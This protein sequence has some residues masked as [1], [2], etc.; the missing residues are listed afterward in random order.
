MQFMVIVKATKD[1]EAGIMPGKELF[2]AM[3]KYNEEL[4][5]AG[6]LLAAEGLQASS[7][8][9]RIRF[10]GMERIVTPGPFPLT[11][12]LVSGFWMWQVESK[13]EAIEWAKRAPF[14]G[15]TEIELRQVF[16][17]EDFQHLLPPEALEQ[18][19]QLRKKVTGKS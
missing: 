18:E 19:E 4:E 10:N 11:T 6:V 1:S 5:K 13:E 14:D 12:D 8:G 17:V 9:A 7:K 3:G 15:D 16:M 2:D